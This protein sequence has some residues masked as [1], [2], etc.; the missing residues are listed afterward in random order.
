[1]Q[2]RKLQKMWIC[3]RGEWCERPFCAKS[4]YWIYWMARLLKIT[5]YNILIQRFKLLEE[6]AE[7]IQRWNFEANSTAVNTIKWLILTCSI[8][9]S[10]IVQSYNRAVPF[11]P[12]VSFSFHSFAIDDGVLRPNVLYCILEAWN[13]VYALG[14]GQKKRKKNCNRIFSEAWTETAVSGKTSGS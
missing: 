14:C 6:L 10:R 12:P 8:D 13:K 7:N 5:N 2:N 9:H 1:M 3:L 4:K 11:L